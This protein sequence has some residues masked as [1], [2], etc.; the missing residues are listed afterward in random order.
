MF[1]NDS[2]VQ[3]HAQEWDY[4]IYGHTVSSFIRLRVEGNS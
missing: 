3:I 4:W 2:F 1:L